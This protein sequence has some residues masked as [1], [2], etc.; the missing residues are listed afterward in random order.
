MRMEAF[1]NLIKVM[2]ALRYYTYRF[3]FSL[4]KFRDKNY[5]LYAL[6]IK[7]RTI[8]VNSMQFPAETNVLGPVPTAIFHR[9]V[10]IRAN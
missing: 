4:I 7:F 3:L 6:R 10:F 2:S 1:L 5:T 8:F 9:A